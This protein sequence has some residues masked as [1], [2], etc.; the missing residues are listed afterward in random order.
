MAGSGTEGV[1]HAERPRPSPPRSEPVTRRPSGMMTIATRPAT[2]DATSARWRAVRGAAAVP[3]GRRRRVTAWR[4]WTLLHQIIRAV[5][6]MSCRNASAVAVRSSKAWVVRRHTSTSIV[7]WRGPPRIRMIPN[8]VKVN[9]NVI[10]AA[11]RSAGRRSGQRDPAASTCRGEAPSVRAASSTP[12]SSCPHSVADRADDHGEV[13]VHVGDQD[14]P[15]GL[16]ER[17]REQGEEGRTDH[18]GREDERARVTSASTR[19]RP[20]KR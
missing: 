15:D 16:V 12:R 11:A 8:E 3:R 10:D 4:D 5:T 20:G 19:P 1:R 13:E 2:V 9:R 7:G 17:G 18:H 6:A 14:R